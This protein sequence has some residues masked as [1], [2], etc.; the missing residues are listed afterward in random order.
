MRRKIESVARSRVTPK[1]EIRQLVEAV[2]DPGQ[3]HVIQGDLFIQGTDV[4]VAVDE[5]ADLGKEFGLQTVLLRRGRQKDD[6]I[7]EEIV[8]RRVG[9]QPMRRTKPNA[10]LD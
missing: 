7:L 4:H 1:P 9:N 2:I 10:R 8:L 5:V 3:D 6:V